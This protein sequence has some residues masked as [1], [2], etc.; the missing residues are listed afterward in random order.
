MCWNVAAV[1]EEE[2]P[3]ADPRPAPETPP[4]LAT[5]DPGWPGPDSI[6]VVAG[7]VE[8]LISIIIFEQ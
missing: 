2:L 3:A 7:G 6:A 1:L 5:G 4:G 8:A